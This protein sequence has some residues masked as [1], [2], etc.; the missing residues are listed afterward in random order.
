MSSGRSRRDKAFNE[1]YARL[2]AS[3]ANMRKRLVAAALIRHQDDPLRPDPDAQ[4]RLTR[5][6][7]VLVRRVSASAHS[8]KRYRPLLEQ[9]TSM[10]ARVR[11]ENQVTGTRTVATTA[12][13][14]RRVLLGDAGP[15]YLGY[16]R[17][18]PGDRLNERGQARTSGGGTTAEVSVRTV[19][20]GLPG[21]GKRT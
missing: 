17:I 11:R 8:S 13:G 10:R 19:S 20:G 1:R 9:V 7:D 6:L 21:L 2:A 15:A 4:R 3:I 18:D 12:G 14:P 5:E 16:E